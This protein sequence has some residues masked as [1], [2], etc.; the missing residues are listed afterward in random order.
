MVERLC[1]GK[2]KGL[3][4]LSLTFKCFLS[5]FLR[6]FHIFYTWFHRV[7]GLRSAGGGWLGH[8]LLQAGVL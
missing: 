8:G 6:R 1:E 4:L 2:E 7:D 5:A 3:S